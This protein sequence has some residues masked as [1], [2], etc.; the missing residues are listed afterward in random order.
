M[1]EYLGEKKVN[2]K[3]TPYKDYTEKDWAFHFIECYGGIDGSHHK[4]W[5]LDQ[6]ARCL[7]GTKVIIK[8]ASWSDGTQEYRISTGAPSA[9]YK[10]WVKDIC[11]GEDGPNTYEYSE[12]VAP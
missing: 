3:D 11:D 2:I 10:R 7:L 8:I 1:P 5:V 6:A 4:D 12:G 9:K